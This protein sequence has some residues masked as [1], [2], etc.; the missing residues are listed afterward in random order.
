MNSEQCGHDLEFSNA[1]RTSLL[2][3]LLPLVDLG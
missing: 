3:V 1:Q 2:E